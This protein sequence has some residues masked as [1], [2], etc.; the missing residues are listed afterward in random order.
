MELDIQKGHLKWTISA[1]ARKCQLSRSLIYKYFGSSKDLILEE[2]VKM[3]GN[4]VGGA[5][6]HKYRL[7]KEGKNLESLMEAREVLENIPNLPAFYY[8]HRTHESS[9]GKLIRK[10]E[11]EQYERIK[12]FF[13]GFDDS[14][15]Q[16]LH[17]L[18]FGLAFTPDIDEEAVEK[19]LRVIKAY[20]KQ[21]GDI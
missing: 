11:R 10:L 14:S 15:Y 9:L 20:K 6:D 18:F 19:G 13:P 3:L 12:V 17:A 4:L 21:K 16:A 8:L 7:W 5:S 1:L 2:A